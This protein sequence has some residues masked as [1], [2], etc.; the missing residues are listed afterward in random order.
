[1]EKYKLYLWCNQSFGDTLVAIPLVERLLEKYG[2]EIDIVFGCYKTH[3]YLLD[4]LPI[5]FITLDIS[6]EPIHRNNDGIFLSFCPPG[7]LPIFT[8]QGQYKDYD[9]VFGYSF[10]WQNVIENFNR[11]ARQYNLPLHLEEIEM[12]VRL[13]N[14]ELDEP[15]RPNAV[16]AECGISRGGQNF[17]QFD[18]NLYASQ[19]PHLNFYC[20]GKP[21]SDLPNIIDC[22]DKDFI[23]IQ[24]IAKHC[25]IFIG[26]GSGPFFLTCINECKDMPRAVF[27]YDF[28]RFQSLWD[29]SNNVRYYDGHHSFV[30]DWIRYQCNRLN[31]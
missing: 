25:K 22:S 19:F 6:D 31:L 26:K 14:I 7:F 16:L 20:I 28:P 13:P 1:M 9:F 15:V 21:N 17:F 30:H 27:G 18:M 11:Q 4:H 24:N 5:R 2:D 23:Y 29:R 3:A 8:V 12:E 10:I